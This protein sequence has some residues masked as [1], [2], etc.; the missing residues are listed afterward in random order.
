MF[1]IFGLVVLSSI[2]TTTTTTTTAAAAAAA[3]AATTTTTTTAAAAVTANECFERP[4]RVGRQS[5]KIN[6]SFLLTTNI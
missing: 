4:T 1:H 5:I 2:P 6:Q 3:A